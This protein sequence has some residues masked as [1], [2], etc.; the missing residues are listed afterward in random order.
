MTGMKKIF[1]LLLAAVLI[2]CSAAA[3]AEEEG[4]VTIDPAADRNITI[5]KAGENTVEEG[6]SPTTGR[7]LAEVAAEIPDEYKERFGGM[8]ATGEYMPLM[9]QV[10]NYASSLGSRAPWFA[11]YADVIYESAK[12]KTGDTRFTMVYSDVLPDWVGCCR[13]LRVQHV[14]IREEWNAPFLYHGCQKNDGN[15]LG[16]DVPTAIRDLGW[17]VPNLTS[18]DR[19]SVFFDGE[20]RRE[21]SSSHYRCTVLGEDNVVYYVP[22]IIENCVKTQEITPRNH[23]CVFSDELPEGGDEA[24]DIY[25]L[26]N[27]N[28]NGQESGA[29]VYY[30]NNLIQYEPE[31]NL[32]Y[33][34]VIR[35]LQHP[36]NAELFEEL[37]P[38][39]IRKEG[40]GTMSCKLV[41]GEPITF[42]NI[43]VQFVNIEWVNGAKDQ[44]LATLTGSGNADYFMGGMHYSGVWNRETLQDR[45]VFYNEN[46]EEMPLQPGKTLIIMMDYNVDVREVRYE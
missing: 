6:I 1:C 24:T 43:I 32:Y 14:W 29:T 15:T 37:T 13:S 3:M 41:N 35:D 38:E 9:V 39:N 25:V 42:S 28:K 34:Y 27:K 31:E 40:Q 26:W 2:L 18:T 7:S 5:H 44:P 22:G 8:S 23:T 12:T 10:T 16:T 33:R 20:C 4:P 46:G 11:S 21:W 45:T 19:V 17:R 36:D 30:F